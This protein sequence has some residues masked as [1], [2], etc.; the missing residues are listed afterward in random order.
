MKYTV[1][2]GSDF[3]VTSLEV[4]DPNLVEAAVKAAKASSDSQARKLIIVMASL[5]GAG[6]IAISAFIGFKDDT[7]NE[8]SS[9]WNV[10]GPIFGG[11]ITYFFS[12]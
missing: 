1:K 4:M 8:V 11:I 12:S 6:A 10:I 9:V 5:F 3:E 2:I 7:Y